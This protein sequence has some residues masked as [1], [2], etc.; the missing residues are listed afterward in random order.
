M[1]LLSCSSQSTQQM[2]ANL[3]GSTFWLWISDL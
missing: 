1:W 3:I 2:T